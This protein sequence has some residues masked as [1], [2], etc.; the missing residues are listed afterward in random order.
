STNPEFDVPQEF[1]KG[2]FFKEAYNDYKSEKYDPY[3]SSQLISIGYYKKSAQTLKKFIAFPMG[4][5]GTDLSLMP[6]SEPYDESYDKELRGS[7]YYIGQHELN[8]S[9][10][11]TLKFKTPVRQITSSISE[12][13]DF[14]FPNPNDVTPSV[15]TAI[16][17]TFFHAMSTES[18]CSFSTAQGLIKPVALDTVLNHSTRTSFEHT[19]VSF[20]PKL[21][22][23]AAIVD[24]GEDMQI[25]EMPTSVASLQFIADQDVGTNPEMQLKYVTK[26]FKLLP[27][28]EAPTVLEI[29]TMFLSWEHVEIYFEKYCREMGFCYRQKSI[30]TD[31]V[32]SVRTIS[33]ACTEGAIYERSKRLRKI[34]PCRWKITLDKAKTDSNIYVTKF[35]NKHNHKTFSPI[36]RSNPAKETVLS[37]DYKFDVHQIFSPMAQDDDISAWESFFRKKLD[38]VD[39]FGHPMTMYPLF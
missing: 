32:G 39:N 10:M 18:D 27:D 1:M 33:Y 11:T 31:I 4:I 14:M 24:C 13:W 22:G 3:M 38:M 28:D 36:F 2:I 9:A 16:G 25:A 29:G 12:R 17:T 5:A 30:T 8:L 20:N 21:Y 34:V 19:H 35:S 23:E 6:I 7:E 15:R 37:N 26:D